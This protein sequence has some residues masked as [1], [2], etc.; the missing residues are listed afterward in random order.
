MAD[1][2]S[3]R[4]SCL[5]EEDVLAVCVEC[6]CSLQGIALSPLFHTLCLTPDTLAFNAHGNVCFMEQLSGES[7]ICPLIGQA[8]HHSLSS[9]SSVSQRFVP[10]LVGRVIIRSHLTHR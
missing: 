1:I 5:S 7:A 4:D 10:R 9:H 6:V 3:L 8:S 2:L